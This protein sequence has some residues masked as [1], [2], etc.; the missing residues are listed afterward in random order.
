MIEP[1]YSECGKPSDIFFED[2]EVT[3]A[4]EKAIRK[5]GVKII[6]G[7]D[8]KDWVLETSDSVFENENTPT[9]VIKS[10]RIESKTENKFVACDALIYFGEKTLPFKTFMGKE[11]TKCSI[12]RCVATFHLAISRTQ[13]FQEQASFSTVDW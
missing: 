11:L 3:E 2:D 12:D 4:V 1:K 8:L 7:W 10:L 5:S 6:S 9:S 13:Q